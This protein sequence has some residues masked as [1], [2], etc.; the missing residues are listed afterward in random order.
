MSVIAAPTYEFTVKK[1]RKLGEVGIF[2]EDARVELL[3]GNIIVM[4]PIGLR[5]A[6]AVRR[7]TKLFVHRYGDGC[8]VDVQSPVMIDGKSEPQPDLLLLRAG[9]DDEL[10]HPQPADVL[11]LVEVADSSLTFD[12]TDKREAYARNGI[13]EYWLL[14]L[15]Q[16]E[17]LVFRDPVGLE[18]RTEL[19]LPAS[20]KI[21][22]LAFPDSPLVVRQIL[23][24]SA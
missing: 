11:L 6:S 15:T 21:A 1:Y 16:N 9:I 18:Y 23:P 13:T 7:M 8:E 4:S 19:R 5:H 2:H 20:E 22:P 3:N 12:R 24:P 10:I 17:L 14:D